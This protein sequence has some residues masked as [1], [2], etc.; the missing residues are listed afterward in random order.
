[1]A[2]ALPPPVLATAVAAVLGWWWV[3]AAGV[4]ATVVLAALA[5]DRYRQ[6]GHRFDGR[7]LAVREGSLLRRWTEL[8]PAEIVSFDLR[9]SPTQRRAGLATLAL[10]LGEGAGSRRALD[11][12]AEQAQ[13][14]LA[15]LQPR[16]FAPLV[17]ARE[18]PDHGERSPAG[19]YR[20]R[21]P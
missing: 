8:D 5:V 10:H 13:A 16:L 7:R 15:E 2:R 18:A 4:A 14:L 12:G 17:G 6:L 11:A 20:R 19:P 21:V 9:S 1:L 3:A